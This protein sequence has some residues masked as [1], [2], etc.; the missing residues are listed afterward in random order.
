ML[1]R[2]SDA[3]H[4]DGATSIRFGSPSSMREFK[5]DA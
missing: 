2:I 5:R 4:H 3:H 1:A